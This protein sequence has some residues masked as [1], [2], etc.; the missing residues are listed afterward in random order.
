MHSRFLLRKV[1]QAVTGN[2]RPFL[3]RPQENVFECSD[4]AS[5]SHSNNI[6]I[7]A[8]SKSEVLGIDF[9]P[10]S[11][12]K[13]KELVDRITNATE[14]EKIQPQFREFIFCAKEAAFKASF[15]TSKKALMADFIFQGHKKIADEIFFK[16]ENIKNKKQFKVYPAIIID[17]IY[18]ETFCL[19]LAKACS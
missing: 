9:E 4:F 8:K 13:N 6:V 11:K 18:S 19:C 3:R 10:L 7:I 12:S 14:R 17:E 5:L 2:S 16:F 1:F 15:L